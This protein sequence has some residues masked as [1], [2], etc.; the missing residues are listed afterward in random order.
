[1]I[2]IAYTSVGLIVGKAGDPDKNGMVV[3]KEPRIVVILKNDGIKINFNMTKL[4]GQPD[5]IEINGA[6]LGN[7]MDENVLNSYNQAISGLII[8]KLQAVSKN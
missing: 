2:K 7:I 6:I 4:F 8:P 3:L 5:F 1:M